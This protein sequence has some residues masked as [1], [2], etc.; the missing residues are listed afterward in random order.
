MYRDNSTSCHHAVTEIYSMFPLRNIEI[1]FNIPDGL[2]WIEMGFSGDKGNT[3]I[4]ILRKLKC[5]TV[6]ICPIQFYY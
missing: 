4:L 6:F 1:P 3:E 5:L 2:L